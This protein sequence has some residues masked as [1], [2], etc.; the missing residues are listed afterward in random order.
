MDTLSSAQIKNLILKIALLL[1]A[2][3]FTFYKS[4]LISLCISLFTCFLTT[5]SIFPSLMLSMS[6]EMDAAL[7]ISLPALY[8]S[9]VIF[10][11]K[12]LLSKI[13]YKIQ[14][15]FIKKNNPIAKATGFNLFLTYRL[16]DNIYIFSCRLLSL[17][18]QYILHYHSGYCQT[19]K[20]NCIYL[21]G[22]CP[23]FLSP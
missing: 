9:F 22:T 8:R 5:L 16:H 14:N 11:K 19:V 20:C 13:F 23:Y 18:I 3:Y 7:L 1:T 17:C 6:F 4:L 15:I 12:F 2:G 10:F 21:S